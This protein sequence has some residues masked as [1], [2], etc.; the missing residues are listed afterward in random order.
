MASKVFESGL[1]VDIGEK[2][3][4]FEKTN[5][6]PFKGLRYDDKLQ[7][8]VAMWGGGIQENIKVGVRNTPRGGKGTEANSPEE[9]N[10]IDTNLLNSY[11]GDAQGIIE[12]DSGIAV[13]NV[14]GRGKLGDF[15]IGYAHNL[16]SS[17]LGITLGSE[18]SGIEFKRWGKDIE[19]EVKD[20]MEKSGISTAELK[21]LKIE[22]DKDDGKF[23]VNYKGEKS[24]IKDFV[25]KAGGNYDTFTKSLDALYTSIEKDGLTF[26]NN[27]ISRTYFGSPNDSGGL[28]VLANGIRVDSQGTRMLEKIDNQTGDGN[29][30]QEAMGGFYKKQLNYVPLEQFAPNLLRRKAKTNSEYEYLPLLDLHIANAQKMQGYIEGLMQAAGNNPEKLKGLI[31]LFGADKQDA[32]WKTL[33]EKEVKDFLSQ[34]EKGLDTYN[35]NAK[36]QDL[37]NMAILYSEAKD[38]A[39]NNLSGG[40]HGTT[41]YWGS[42]AGQGIR[43]A[44]NQELRKY[45]ALE[46]KLSTE[47]EYFLTQGQEKVMLKEE[48]TTDYAVFDEQGMKRVKGT[49]DFNVS[50][51]TV[52][53]GDSRQKVAVVTGEGE[54]EVV[55]QGTMQGIGSVHVEN[56]DSTYELFNKGKVT[57]AENNKDVY[58]KDNVQVKEGETLRDGRAQEFHTVFTGLTP[59]TEAGHNKL[60]E[61]AFS[62][63]GSFWTFNSPF[64]VDYNSTGKS[65]TA[66]Q[67]IAT[68]ALVSSPHLRGMSWETDSSGDRLVF[69]LNNAVGL[70]NLYFNGDK[71]R[72]RLNPGD[73]YKADSKY[74]SN[75]GDKNKP[76][77]GKLAEKAIIYASGK[78]PYI[79]YS[80]KT[81]D[82]EKTNVPVY[83]DLEKSF[84]GYYYGFAS[85]GSRIGDGIYEKGTFVWERDENKDVLGALRF[86]GIASLNNDS[87]RFVGKYV[88]GVSGRRWQEDYSGV[89]AVEWELQNLK[90]A[91][92]RWQASLEAY[93]AGS[94]DAAEV[95]KQ[96]QGFQTALRD[97]NKFVSTGK[98]EPL[99][100]KQDIIGWGGV[101]GQQKIGEDASGA[102]IY[103]N[104]LMD[105]GPIAKGQMEF[106]GVSELAVNK[107]LLL[108]D[109]ILPIVIGEKPEEV[110]SDIQEPRVFPQ[111]IYKNPYFKNSR[112]TDGLV[113]EGR[114]DIRVSGIHTLL[115]NGINDEGKISLDPTLGYG[116]TFLETGGNI[117]WYLQQLDYL[118][119]N[120][121]VALIMFYEKKAKAKTR[122]MSIVCR[123]EMRIRR[124]LKGH[125]LIRLI[126]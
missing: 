67:G 11:V 28:F 126:S 99:V 19:Q 64:D 123:S 73:L 34:I 44:L 23:Y 72:I 69:A 48:K 109:S 77:T 93:N 83:N 61:A 119:Q 12:G 27:G 13:V 29:I 17:D 6:V 62:G 58:G 92:I 89:G 76:D 120:N 60:S 9:I 2:G 14:F 5:L 108:K 31:A 110:V 51:N 112:S 21:N 87:N 106:D 26:K 54:K 35:D 121:S 47:K 8:L 45:R 59:S 57:F 39:D 94:C 36:L 91:R 63:I 125:L 16:G 117:D 56:D 55:N 114:F 88:W 75:A 100:F 1:F 42:N 30:S 105:S 103:R 81:V 90:D 107:N 96:K 116:G 38:K 95:D 52:G 80:Q 78:N 101:W 97:F 122:P 98:K 24:E 65:Y 32:R 40:G 43:V 102:P 85:D 118:K 50:S 25:R 37:M 18:G 84:A 7:V 3:Y 66:A 124:R 41:G 68:S 22:K 49:N 20:S 46:D 104:V 111:Q 74:D 4:G 79:A 113:S 82:G 33:G 15:F 71:S 70:P 10:T 53:F 86:N 115:F